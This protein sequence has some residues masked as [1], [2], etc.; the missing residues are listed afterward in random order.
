M[1][2]VEFTLC[3]EPLQSA[4][5]RQEMEYLP[6]FQ[7]DRWTKLFQE[8]VCKRHSDPDVSRTVQQ[9]REQF[10]KELNDAGAEILFGTDSPNLFEVPGFSVYDELS[11]MQ[12]SGLSPYDVLLSAT[13]R[14]GEYLHKNV[15]AVTVGAQADLVL[16]DAN[17]LDDTANVRK[18]AGVMVRGRWLAH[19]EVQRILQSIHD[20]RENYRVPPDK[21]AARTSDEKVT[22][23]AAQGR[24]STTD[25]DTLYRPVFVDNAEYQTIITKPKTAGRH[26]AVLLIGGLGCYSLDHLKPDDAYAQLLYGLTRKGYVTM[27]VEK[28]GEGASQGPPCDSAQSDL[29]LA[30]RRS[31]AGLNL[32]ADSEYVD[33]QRIFV[34]AHSIGPLEGVLVAQKFPIR[35]FIAAETI[36]KSWFEYQLENLRRQTLLLGGPYDEADRSVRTLERCLHRFLVEKKPP[37]QI[38]RDAPE[39]ADSVNTFGVSY[40][41][42]QQIADLDLAAEWKKVDVP[43]LVTWGTSDPTTTADESR[44]LVEMINSFHPGRA[45]YAEFPGMGH[46]LDLSPSPRAWLEAIHNHRHGKF[47]QDFLDRVEAW[48]GNA[49]QRGNGN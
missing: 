16:L 26:P 36:G 49:V 11:A 15:G 34:F 12:H 37:D 21:R 42:L 13:R 48:L 44:Y 19:S 30:V 35:G 29:R 18:Q 9:N 2:I 1:A 4:L 25:F 17:P 41:Y 24:E 40:S 33:R 10:L 46:G 38:V 39:C 8:V 6:K 5:A 14:V 45:T 47:D 27:R 22:A 31:L 32:L 28:N 20:L 23:A 7:V 43:V 3:Q